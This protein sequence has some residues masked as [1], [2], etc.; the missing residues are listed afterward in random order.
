MQNIYIYM[1]RSQILFFKI[2][3]L[4]WNLVLDIFH[5]FVYMINHMNAK[6]RVFGTYVLVY[7]AIWIFWYIMIMW[8]RGIFYLIFFY[9]WNI[10][11]VF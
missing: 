7:L 10:L 8:F 5:L 3:C 11:H 6:K 4:Y 1:L 9:L 2:T